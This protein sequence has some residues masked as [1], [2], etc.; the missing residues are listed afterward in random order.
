MSTEDGSLRVLKSVDWRG[1]SHMLFSPDGKYVAF[2]SQLPAHDGGLQRDVFIL[3]IDGSREIPAV[4]HPSDDAVVA[5]SPDGTRLLFTST[6]PWAITW[7][8]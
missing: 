6:C 7:R 3:A 2:D 4:A 5:W 8:A 1:P